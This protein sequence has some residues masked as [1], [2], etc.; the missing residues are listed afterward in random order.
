MPFTVLYR[1]SAGS[2]PGS[3]RSGP[4]INCGLIRGLERG[5]SVHEGF[6]KPR[7]PACNKQLATPQLVIGGVPRLVLG[8]FGMTYFYVTKLAQFSVNQ[9]SGPD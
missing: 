1:S 3:L 9:L 2:C 4:L 8:E 5:M 6:W 7:I